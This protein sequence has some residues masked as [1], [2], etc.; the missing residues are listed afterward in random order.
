MKK[1][2][3]EIS[4]LLGLMLLCDYA[5][6]QSE[7]GHTNFTFVDESRG[8]RSIFTEIYYP[9]TAAGDDVPFE[10]GT[11][12]L[13][14]FGHGFVM[15]YTAYQNI[16]E[17]LVPE[18]YIMAFVTTEGGIAP[19]HQDF[20]LDLSF[21]LD[22]MLIENLNTQSVFFNTMSDQQALMGHSMGGG[23]SWLAAAM[24][25]N[26]DAV[27]GLAP[28]ETN[29]SAIDAASSVNCSALVLSG[30]ADAVTP[31][32]EHHIPIYNSTVMGC[33]MMVTYD[34]GSHCG[35][36][37]SGS[38][39]DLGELGFNGMTRETQQAHTAELLKLWL[40]VAL[41][42]NEIFNEGIISYDIEESDVE[43]SFECI[44]GVE[45]EVF[46][47]ELILWP[48][49]CN[50]HVNIPVPSNHETYSIRLWDMQGKLLSTSQIQPAG[51][52]VNV[53][54][55]ALSEGMYVVECSSADQV[56]RAR[57]CVEH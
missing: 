41:L 46:P 36:A 25:T 4:G 14:V 10:A 55:S 53:V 9:A 37:N 56:L 40:P 39:C 7:I 16:W 19:S 15:G 27:V 50:E 51:G 31:P 32:D 29:P 11:H 35:F 8:N 17:A 22:G 57:L 3:L 24:N 5:K 45:E 23:C 20:A 47:A 34:Q 28:A 13:I 30:S 12:P 54:T 6:A 18:G 52:M 38:L 21:V 33:K 44:T 2:L 48:Q 43:L 26:V 42:N 49:P 1:N